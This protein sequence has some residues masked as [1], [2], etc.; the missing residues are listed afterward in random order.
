MKSYFRILAIVT[1]GLLLCACNGAKT[2][3]TPTGTLSTNLRPS[4][5][6]ATNAPFSLIDGGRVWASP[7]SDMMPG[8]ADASFDYAVYANPAVS[9]ASAFAYAAIIRLTDKESWE[10]LPQ[11]AKLS[12]SFGGR[13]GVAGMPGGYA[14]TVHVPGAGD[15]AAELLAANGT[16]VPEAWVA[17]RWLFSLDP[18][19]R[20]LAE[21]REPWPADLE[22]PEEDIMLLREKHAAFLR[23]FDRRATAAFS[24]DRS[25]GDFGDNAPRVSTWNKASVLPDVGKIAGEV[26][27]RENN[28]DNFTD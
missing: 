9:P 27:R 7:K 20:A 11:G 16:A 10:F 1:A 28:P 18:D 6:I 8:S 15:W 2:G 19:V 21:Y 23:E 25:R 14:Y 3:V 22:Y 13:K 26:M 17:K 4:I 5:T 12:G 24:F